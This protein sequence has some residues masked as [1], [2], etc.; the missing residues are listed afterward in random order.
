MYEK[1]HRNR[2][3]FDRFYKVIDKKHI[4]NAIR[5]YLDYANNSR[6]TISSNGMKPFA[7]HSSVSTY[8]A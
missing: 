1:T 8:N 6:Y 7:N 5:I 4:E 2:C 3:A